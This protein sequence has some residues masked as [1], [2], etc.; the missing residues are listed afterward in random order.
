[1]REFKI[2]DK[3]FVRVFRNLVEA[4]ILEGVSTEEIGL[5]AFLISHVDCNMFATMP[6]QDDPKRLVHIGMAAKD[7]S[8]I[9][10]VAQN[11][12]SSIRFYPSHIVLETRFHTSNSIFNSVCMNRRTLRRM[13]A[14]VRAKL[15]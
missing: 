3:I 6:T 7:S 14:H 5:L 2:H 9:G 8:R 13:M 12:Q 11:I 15:R 4:V 10:Q 1:M